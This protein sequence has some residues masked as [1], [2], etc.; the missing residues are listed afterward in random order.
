MHCCSPGIQSDSTASLH[1]RSH[2]PDILFAG[3]G[4]SMGKHCWFASPG[5]CVL[6]DYIN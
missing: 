4:G 5:D 3:P 6:L 2:D 1:E